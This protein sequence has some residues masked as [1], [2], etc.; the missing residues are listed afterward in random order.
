VNYS[1]AAN[2][3]PAR[4]GTITIVG[5]TFTVHQA[6]AI[7]NLTVNITGNG[8]LRFDPPPPFPVGTKVTVYFEPADGFDI[9]DIIVDG[10]SM[11]AVFPMWPVYA[12]TFGDLSEDHTIDII[13]G[14]LPALLIS[15]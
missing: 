15:E 7:Y 6:A 5:Q 14:K 12:F 8:T 9:L 2:T 11:K 4:D 1:V 3:G 13:F 10:I